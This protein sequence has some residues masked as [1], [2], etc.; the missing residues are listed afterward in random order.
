[1]TSSAFTGVILAMTMAWSVCDI[2]CQTAAAQSPVPDLWDR[3]IAAEPLDKVPFHS[4]RIPSWVRTTIGCGYTL[5]AM[6]TDAR[7]AAA[8]HGV[9]ISE[10]NFV[11]PFYPY[12]DSKMLHRRSPHV[13]LGKIEADLAEYESI[14][15][16]VLAVYPPCLQGEVYQAHPEWRRI[17]TNTAEIPEVDL[18]QHPYGGMLCLL[19]PYG[20]FFIDV[21]AEILTLYPQ[22]DAFSFDGLHYGGVCYCQ[23]CREDY[24]TETGQE[25]PDV[26]MEDPLFRRYQHWA[27][28]RM[29]DLVRRMQVRLKTIKPEVA[30]VTW[31]TNAGRFG[32][33][34]SIPRNMPSRMNLLLDAPDQEFWM[35]ESNRGTT[36]VP[37]FTNAYVWA[38]TD[39]RVAFSEPYILSHGNPYGKD[40]FPPHEIERRML[41]ALTYGAQ[42]S[43]AVAQPERL[44]GALYE[45]MDKIQARKAWLTNKSPEPWAAILMSDNTRNFYGRSSGLVETRYLANVLGVF[46]TAV[47]EHLCATVINDWNLNP[48]DLAKYS[49]LVLPN[50]ACLNETQAAAVR[51]FVAQGGG[52]VASL[53]TSRFNEFGDARDNF[54]LADLFGADY[55]GLPEESATTAEIDVNFAKSIG[56]D[57]W[58]KQKGIYDFRL[59]QSTFFDQDL[60]H[61]YIGTDPVTFKGAAVRVRPMPQATIEATFT[62]RNL[63]GAVEMPAAISTEFGKGQ[64][65]YFPSGIDG[66]YYLY[67]YPYQRLLLRDAIARV[68]RTA[69]P[70]TV[71]APMCVH[72]TLMRQQDESGQRLIAH[73]F[74][75]LNTTGQHAIPVDDIPLREEA[76]PIHGIRVGFNPRYRMSRLTLQPD[77]VELQPEVTETGTFV[78]L[79]P[80]ETHFMVVAELAVP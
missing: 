16:R 62:T 1:M 49:V 40:S 74:S 51:D 54:L 41:L 76:I 20:D 28:R 44:Q 2:V 6:G 43:I 45:T 33:F 36:I 47:E 37:A 46:R 11:D 63:A 70:I 60:T 75:D 3:Q 65:I 61:T 21:L 30:L 13:P 72:T 23:H 53:D 12:Y 77:N 17:A 24:R 79:P 58:E 67:A 5:S 52:L 18:Q 42:P 56:P 55:V 10:V 22:V 8:K 57:Y 66:A 29:E 71:T 73:F 9:T 50:A 34:L 39:H 59:R 32:H 68:A 14:G 48:E 4:I 38:T 27:D 15:V 7:V 35:D 78:T 19:G 69:P 25:I 80:L 31:T 26:N 64:V